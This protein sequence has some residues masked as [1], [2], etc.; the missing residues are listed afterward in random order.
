[1]SVPFERPPG[2]DKIVYS[3]HSGGIPVKRGD[4]GGYY[5]KQNDDPIQLGFS[6]ATT[7]PQILHSEVYYLENVDH[8]LC[9][10]SLCDTDFF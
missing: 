2:W 5:I 1:M 9:N 6:N 3:S 10:I 7:D 4:V 8:P